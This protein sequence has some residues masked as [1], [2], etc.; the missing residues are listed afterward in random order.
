MIGAA[1]FVFVWA[2]LDGLDCLCKVAEEKCELRRLEIEKLK[3]ELH[4]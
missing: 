1:T 4:Q 3:K 2:I